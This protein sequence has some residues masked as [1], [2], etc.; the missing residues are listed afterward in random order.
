M[1]SFEQIV[2]IFNDY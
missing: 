1:T 2:L